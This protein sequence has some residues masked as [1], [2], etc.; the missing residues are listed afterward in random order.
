MRRFGNNKKGFSLAEL[1]IVVAIIAVLVAIAI[2]VFTKQLEKSR[3][4]T[5]LANIRSGYSIVMTEVL[6]GNNPY[7]TE[8]T[9]YVVDLIQRADGWITGNAQS[10]LEKLGTVVGAPQEQGCCKIY[11]DD[12]TQKCILKFAGSKPV[13]PLD[14]YTGKTNQ[15]AQDFYALVNY[16]R[17]QTDYPNIVSLL[18]NRGTKDITID[19]QTVSFYYFQTGDGQVWSYV[20]DAMRDLGYTDAEIGSMRGSFAGIYMDLDGNLVAYAGPSS[21]GT[22]P[23]IFIDDPDT[24]LRLAG[25]AEM[26]PEVARHLL[27]GASSGV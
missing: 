4:A 21:G 27:E 20:S 25:N 14:N 5:D 1:L 18:N 19:G 26:D 13:S 23:L 9:A 24:T 8:E 11:Y 7:N 12:A 16:F 3:E 10:S 17:N 22:N 6:S 2:P 15:L